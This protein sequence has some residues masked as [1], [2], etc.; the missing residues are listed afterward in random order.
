MLPIT[1]LIL[2]NRELGLVLAVLIGF[3]FG[4]VLERAGFGRADKLAAQFYLH[5]MTVFKVMFGAIITASLGVMVL[6]GL[7]VADLKLISESAVSYTYLWPQLVGGLLLGVGFIVSG[8][9]PGTSTVAMASGNVDAIFTF[10]GVVIGSVIYSEA[11][12]L[13]QSFHTSGEMGHL[14]LYDLLNIPPQVLA[15]LVAGMAI[16]MFFGA[17][18][19]EKIFTAK[20]NGGDVEAAAAKVW[21]PRRLAFGSVG[22]LMVVALATL[23]L[24]NT[25]SAAVTRN[26]KAFSTIT[27]AELAQ[28]IIDEPWK[29]RILDLRASEYCEKRRVPGAECVPWKEVPKL[30]LPYSSGA[31]DLVLVYHN[32]LDRIPPDARDYPG[33]V[34]VAKGGCKAWYAFA[35]TPPRPPG[36]EATSEQYD[37]YRFRSALQ[38][39]LTGRKAAP[40]PRAVKKFTPAP[41]KKKGG[42]CG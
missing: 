14:F 23:A 36:Q 37:L 10:L 27:P 13:L 4:F 42:G 21:Q 31:R 29:L 24:P 30:G 7:G 12:P 19:V 38:S 25:P 6:S 28:R 20:R 32:S 17:E 5:D 35:Y 41:R 26:E 2:E 16:A 22:V 34:Y 3:A 33:K 8:Y 9:C 11:F 40:P 15:V 1:N 18:K 39:A